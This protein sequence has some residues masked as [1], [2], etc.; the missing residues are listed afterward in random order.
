MKRIPCTFTLRVKMLVRT[1]KGA[2]G[3]GHI[4]DIAHKK[5]MISNLHKIGNIC[6]KHKKMAHRGRFCSGHAARKCAEF[7]YEKFTHKLAVVAD[8]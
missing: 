7:A 4:Y 1:S 6:R 8:G 5:C 3:L 2:D